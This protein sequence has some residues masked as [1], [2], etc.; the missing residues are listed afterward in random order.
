MKSAGWFESVAGEDKVEKMKEVLDASGFTKS[1]NNLRHTKGGSDMADEAK[2]DEVVEKA[3]EETVEAV[4]EVVEKST[5]EDEGTEA[6][7]PDLQGI[8]KAL[9]EIK[10][11]LAN[12]T[13]TGET[14]EAAIVDIKKTV[15]GVEKNV[16]TRME[17]LL[18][19]HT[20]LAADFKALKEGLGGVE[21]RL[22]SV[23]SSSA[24]KKSADVESDSHIEKSGKQEQKPFWSSAFLPKDFD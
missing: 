23:E 21:K 24:I 4:E 1:D 11:T 2:N 17:E 16:E 14:R 7:E 13:Q 22:T 12:V 9:E 10:S 15:D 8:A 18:K 3:A 19:A 20:E 6:T 5:S